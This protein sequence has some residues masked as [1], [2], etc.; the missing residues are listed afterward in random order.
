MV[1]LHHLVLLHLMAIQEME[2]CVKV[3]GM[4]GIEIGSNI[5]TKNLGDPYF[6]PFWAAAEAL[7]CCLFIHPWEMMGEQD[8]TQY[9]LPWLVGMPAETSRAICSLIF[10]GVLERY[11]KLRIAF[12]PRSCKTKAHQITA[13]IDIKAQTTPNNKKA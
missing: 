13:K 1:L 6:E 10:S 11:P 3:L 2:R 9:W 12:A 8:M 5:N 7:D 4:P